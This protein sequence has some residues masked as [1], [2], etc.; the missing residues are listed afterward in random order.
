MKQ[1]QADPNNFKTITDKTSLY[2][3]QQ[4][5]YIFVTGLIILT[6]KILI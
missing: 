6:V 3:F 1:H 2:Q 5:M 4:C